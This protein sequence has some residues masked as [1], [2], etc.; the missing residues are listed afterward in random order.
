MSQLTDAIKS[1]KP[2]ERLKA[3]IFLAVLTSATAI[4]TVY[5]KTDDCSDTANNYNGCIENYSKVQ[6]FAN[7]CMQESNR[8]TGDLIVLAGI[9]DS[10]QRCKAIQYTTTST[11]T[12]AANRRT[13]YEITN[14]TVLVNANVRFPVTETDENTSSDRTKIVKTQTTISLPNNQKKLVDSAKNILQKYRRQ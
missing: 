9:I 12:I 5:L 1:L 3:F 4:T 2:A 14:D 11:S 8:K 6:T 10:L 7:S 13:A